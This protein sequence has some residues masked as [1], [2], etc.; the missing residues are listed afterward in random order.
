M[1]NKVINWSEWNWEQPRD[2]AETKIQE[3]EDGSFATTSLMVMNDCIKMMFCLQQ[4][5]SLKDLLAWAAS[6]PQQLIK[7]LMKICLSFHQI[8]KIEN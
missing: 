6:D 2:F 4:N 7:I 8:V 3:Y 5:G 1:Q